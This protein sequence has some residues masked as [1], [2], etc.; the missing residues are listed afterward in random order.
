MKHVFSVLGGSGSTFLRRGIRKSGYIIAMRPEACWMPNFQS[1]NAHEKQQIL[2]KK[3][4]RDFPEEKTKEQFY[5]R[6]NYG[7]SVPISFKLDLKKNINEN[8]KIYINFLLSNKERTAIF[9]HASK[10]QFFSNNNIKNVV[11]LVRHPLMSYMSLVKPGR[12]PGVVRELGGPN[13]IGGVSFYA[14]M[15]N[16]YAKDI[17]ESKRRKLN[18]IIIRYEFAGS[19]LEKYKNPILNKIFKDFRSNKRYYNELSCDVENKLREITKSSYEKIF[20]TK[21]EI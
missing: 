21:W 3:G 6:A 17:V 4:Y 8:L 1:A 7:R 19:D 13:S 20:N 16:L 12:H 15:W 11:F 2:S 10:L 5:I 18:P 9:T 14:K